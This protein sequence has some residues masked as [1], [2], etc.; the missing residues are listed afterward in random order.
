[1]THWHAESCRDSLGNK[2]MGQL[3]RCWVPWCRPHLHDRGT[4]RASY[5]QHWCCV[6]TQCAETSQL[7]QCVD[8]GEGGS[9]WSPAVSPP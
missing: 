5:K 2:D 6:Q 8:M 1:M 4:R 9:T 3:Q 7:H